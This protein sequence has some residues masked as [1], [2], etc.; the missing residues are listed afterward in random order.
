M[1]GTLQPLVSSFPG[2]AGSLPVLPF[3]LYVNNRTVTVAEDE[4]VPAG[5]KYVVIDSDADAWIANGSG[6]AVVPSGDTVDGSGSIF[7]KAGVISP[8]FRVQAAQILS[9][10]SATGTAH[11]SFWYYSSLGTA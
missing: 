7:F 3:P 1:P 11:V 10:V 9:T 5:A 8:P 6:L 2:I 4:T